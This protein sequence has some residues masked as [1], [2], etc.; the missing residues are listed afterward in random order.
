MKVFGVLGISERVE[1]PRGGVGDEIKEQG[2]QDSA[3]EQREEGRFRFK[4]A[5]EPDEAHVGSII[6]EL[7]FEYWQFEH[8]P[9][10]VEV[11]EI[12]PDIGNPGE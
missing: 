1:E 8:T 4:G 7:I 5:P 9:A 6:E 12:Q 10:Q 11:I 2:A 3:T